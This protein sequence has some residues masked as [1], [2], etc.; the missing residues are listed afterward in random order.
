MSGIKNTVLLLA[1]G[2]GGL[3]H[4]GQM[5]TWTV[6]GHIHRVDVSPD[7]TFADVWSRFA[8]G[9]TFAATFKVDLDAVPSV[10]AGFAYAVDSSIEFKEAGLTYQLTFI[11]DGI[12]VGLG[13]LD[14]GYGYGALKGG[15]VQSPG[16][17][18]SWHF[19]G[20]I[21]ASPRW[22]P[23]LRTANAAIQAGA[24]SFNPIQFGFVGS[25]LGNLGTYIL[26]S[27]DRVTTSVVPEPHIVL[28]ELAGGLPCALVLALRRRRKA[29]RREE[30][31]T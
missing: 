22:Q 11:G 13:G 26:A 3:A 6:E 18:H 25:D 9:Q 28:M 15:S 17:A 1:L 31:R 14:L 23:P 19:S 24:L 5:A 27:V 30:A 16:V 29:A 4:A 10:G 7:P 2:L 21:P 12:S 20:E 8:P